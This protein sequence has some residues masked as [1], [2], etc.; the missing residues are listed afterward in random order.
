TAQAQKGALGSADDAAKLVDE[1][2]RVA[3]QGAENPFLGVWFADANNGFVV[4]AF[5]LIFRTSDGGK[6]W[7]PWF[8]RTDNPNR[9]HLYAVQG[10]GPLVVITGEQ[11]LVLRLE[12][13][14]NHF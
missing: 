3:A 7:E 12:A 4:G 10:I 6:T 2:K 8:H 5:N 13:G 1:A 11:G 14:G 9:L